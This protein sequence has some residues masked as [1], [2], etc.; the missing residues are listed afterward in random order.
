M[1]CRTLKTVQDKAVDKE[2]GSS[3]YATVRD[4]LFG[5]GPPAAA[6]PAIP[7]EKLKGNA[8][9]FSSIKFKMFPKSTE[10]YEVMSFSKV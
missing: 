6:K 3:F 2:K 7:P 10:K 5:A 4:K 1:P 9:N 8:I